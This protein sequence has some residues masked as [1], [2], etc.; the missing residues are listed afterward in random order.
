MTTQIKIE[1][2][3]HLKWSLQQQQNDSVMKQSHNGNENNDWISIELTWAPILHE[4]IYDRHKV[5]INNKK[6]DFENL[7]LCK[8]CANCRILSWLY[9]VVFLFS[10]SSIQ[11]LVILAQG[12]SK[13]KF[14]KNEKMHW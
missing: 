14:G 11:I 3:F 5:H 1:I 2:I 8:K 13:R 9:D 7:I 4:N 6:Y 10:I 12:R